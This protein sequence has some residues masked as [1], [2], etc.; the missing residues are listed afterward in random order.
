MRLLALF[1]MSLATLGVTPGFARACSCTSDES[2]RRKVADLV[3]RG[4]VT[5]VSMSVE[6]EPSCSYDADLLGQPVAEGCVR[7][8]FRTSRC[9]GARN[10]GLQLISSDGVQ[11]TRR[12][13]DGNGNLEVCGLV[14]QVTAY[15]WTP[16]ATGRIFSLTPGEDVVH[17]LPVP[18]KRLTRIRTEFVVAEVLKG[19]RVSRVVIWTTS[20]QGLCGYGQFDRQREYEVVA[21]RR[22]GADLEHPEYDVDLCSGT[23]PTAKRIQVPAKVQI[24]PLDFLEARP[25]G[26]D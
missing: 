17:L 26:S 10:V 12:F 21:R 16:R 25:Q 1:L 22:R 9:E 7:V 14:G 24:R 8:A 18:E 3:F 20:D 13:S 11:Q 4:H 2:A 19:P 15:S 6:D 5:K 23:K